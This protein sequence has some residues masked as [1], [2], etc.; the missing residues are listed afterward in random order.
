LLI[1]HCNDFFPDLRLLVGLVHRWQG[2]QFGL[3]WQ[4]IQDAPQDALP[5]CIVPELEE[6]RLMALE[7]EKMLFD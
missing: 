5:N 1:V 7:L 3:L 2:V 6:T 4:P